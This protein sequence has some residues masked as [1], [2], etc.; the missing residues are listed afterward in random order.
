MLD[1]AQR[2]FEDVEPGDEFDEPWVPT[3]ASVLAYLAV[4]NPE[5]GNRPDRFTDDEAAR[6]IGMPRA[7]VPGALSLCMA[8]RLVTDWMGPQGKLQSIDVDYRRAALHDDNLRI[9]GL[10]TDT[11]EVD[12]APV[13]KLD[14]YIENDR[15]ERPLQGVAVVELPRRT[16]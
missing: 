10:V 12:G 1:V 6:K 16:D 15:G 13:I 8:T 14:V 7:I 5:A 9:L 3:H 4:G 11:D 2:Y